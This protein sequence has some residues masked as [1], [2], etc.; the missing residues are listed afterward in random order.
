VTDRT[1]TRP[2]HLDGLD[3]AKADGLVPVVAQDADDGRVLMVA[4]ATREALERT[5]ETGRAWFFSRSRNALWMKGETSGNVL[6]LVSLHADCDGDT[7]LARVRPTGPACHTGEETCFGEGAAPASDGRAVPAADD[8]AMSPHVLTELEAV[9]EARR[10]ERPEGSY[11]VR[12]LEDENLRLKKLG[13][14][15]AELV[16]ALAKADPDRIP[17]EAG[18][19]IY[20]VLAAL[21]GAGVE[22]AEVWRVLER[23]RG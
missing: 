12:L 22:L 11:T 7:V 20:H 23:R 19:L 16:T 4:W 10:T 8:R 2:G 15:T 17:E 21:R 5:L 6:E 1:L 14:E 18:D 13:E 3:F 9:L